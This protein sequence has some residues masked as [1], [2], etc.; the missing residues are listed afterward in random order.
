MLGLGVLFGEL[1]WLGLTVLNGVNWSFSK[2]LGESLLF[3]LK[4][5]ELALCEPFSELISS[6]FVSCSGCDTCFRGRREGPRRSMKL[7]EPIRGRVKLLLCWEIGE[8][9]EFESPPADICRETGRFFGDGVEVC[10]GW[11]LLSDVGVLC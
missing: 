2:K 9:F 10:R 3:F 4:S 1:L 5:S 8:V 11:L 7:S 6:G